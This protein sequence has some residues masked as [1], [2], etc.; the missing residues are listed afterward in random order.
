MERGVWWEG[1]EEKLRSKE[2]AFLCSGSSPM[3]PRISLSM[4]QDPALPWMD[5]EDTSGPIAPWRTTSMATW[6][7]WVGETDVGERGFFF[8]EAP[9]SSFSSVLFFSF[10][11]DTGEVYVNS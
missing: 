6:A 10:W 11:R 2:P 7:S 9:A 3:A 8:V 5:S 4:G 1:G